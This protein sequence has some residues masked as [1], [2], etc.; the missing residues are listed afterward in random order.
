MPKKK[1]M[2]DRP[3][4][5]NPEER[6]TPI[7]AVLVYNPGSGKGMGATRTEDFARHWKERVGPGLRLRATRSREDIRVAA[8]DFEGGEDEIRIFMGGDGTLSEGLQGVAEYRDFDLSGFPP[9]RFLPGGTGN[10]FLRDFGIESYEDGRDALLAALARPEF[11]EVDAAIVSYRSCEADRSVASGQECRRLMFNIFGVGL[12]SD[13]TGLA[14]RMRYLGPA[15]Y[16]VATLWKILS[17]RPHRWKLAVDGE[18]AEISCDLVT[19]SNSR[20]TGGA[21]EIAPEIRVNDGKLFLVI[22]ETSFRLDLFRVFPRILKGDYEGETR[23]RTRFIRSL[24]LEDE[25]PFLMN[26][27][28]ELE[29]GFSPAMEIKPSFFRLYL[30]K[31]RLDSAF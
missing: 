17:H 12:I 29:T 2:D 13:I 8:R 22:V 25:R 18:P 30:P 23:V 21:M 7:R 3:T 15:N 28:G 26:I 4:D 20:Y 5:L 6:G 9:V 16:H 24:S 14:T 10:S 27:D 11:V 1:H 19:V 31:S